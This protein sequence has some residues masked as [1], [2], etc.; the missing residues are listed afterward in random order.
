MVIAIRQDDVFRRAVES[1][2]RELVMFD[3]DKAG[4][5][6]QTPLLYGGGSGVVIRIEPAA[7]RYFVSDFGLGA[8]EAH[9]LGA[10][11]SQYANCGKKV[12]DSSGIG[13]DQHSFFVLEASREQL[14][15]AIVA[16]ANCSQT[17]VAII[18]YKVA[19]KQAAD[20]KELLF[21][22]LVEVF[23]PSAVAKDAVVKG[24]SSTPWEIS[25]LV[26]LPHSLSAFE[27]V[28]NHANSIASVA[29]K[30][31]DIALM[32]NGPRR[33]AIV[34]SKKELGTYLGVLAQVSDVLEDKVANDVL[35]KLASAA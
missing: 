20:E 1:V 2:A 15:G 18:A 30:F 6:I 12:A 27:P 26:R 34:K 25:A 8:Q 32:E 4:T 17:A 16:V 29:M 5:F 3:H 21:R 19:E 28:R 22:R 11:P 13:F 31:N 35:R 7:D 9:L 14:A 10:T 24:A 33:F 23:S